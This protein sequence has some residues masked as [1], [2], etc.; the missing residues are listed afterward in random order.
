[1]KFDPRYFV[2]IANRSGVR[3]SLNNSRSI[4]ITSNENEAAAL[5]VVAAKKHKKKLLRY[6]RE[7]Q[8]KGKQ[9]DLFED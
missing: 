9:L 4:L 6:L 3:L 2:T 5:W 8:E 1:M 7:E